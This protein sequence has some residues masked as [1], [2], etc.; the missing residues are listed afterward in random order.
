MAIRALLPSLSYVAHFAR[1]IHFLA[2]SRQI[3]RVRVIFLK[4]L[5]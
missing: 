2:R 4:S 1:Q 5:E 3:L